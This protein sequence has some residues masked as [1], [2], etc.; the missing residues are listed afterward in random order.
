MGHHKLN[1]EQLRVLGDR[2]DPFYPLTAAEM[3]HGKRSTR[4]RLDRFL[5]MVRVAASASPALVTALAAIVM[6]GG[7]SLSN[8]LTWD[9]LVSEGRWCE[10]RWL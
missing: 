4:R 10:L 5:K 6:T 9:S 3:G 7:P 8:N 2:R 1:R